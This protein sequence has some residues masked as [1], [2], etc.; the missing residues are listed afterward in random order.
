MAKRHKTGTRY[1][2]NL[3]FEYGVE[4]RR[5]AR[6]LCEKR[7]VVLKARDARSAIKKAKQYGKRHE[8]SYRNADG[9]RFRIRFLGLVD[10]LALEFADP[11]E[12]YYSLFRTSLPARHLRP[13]QKLAVFRKL[14]GT[15][16]SSWWAVPAWLTRPSPKRSDNRRG[17]KRHA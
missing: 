7:I 10:V 4:R 2:A 9:H 8:V 5:T 6:P 12:V 15:I 3:L 13:A 14:R 17:S 1:A 11:E 16:G